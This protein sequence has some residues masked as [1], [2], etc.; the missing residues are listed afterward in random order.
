METHPDVPGTSKHPDFLVH[1]SQPFYLE[2]VSVG[3]APEKRT[4]E[5]R[6]RDVEAI[7]DNT[8]VDGWTLSFEWHRIGP[9]PPKAVRLRNR[10]VTWLDDLDRSHDTDEYAGRPKFS[11]DD[12]G[13]KLD[14]TA[15][16][17]GSDQ[18]PL[19]AI[20]GAGRARGAD[21]KA[22]L[23]R[24]LGAKSNRYGADLPYPLVTAVLSNTESPTRP[25]DVQ[26]TL[27]GMHWLGPSQV[28]DFTELSTDGH[29]RTIHGW[30][31]SHNPY[32]VVGSGISL[33]NIHKAVPWLWRTLD[34]AVTVNLHMPWAAPIDVTV[35][36][37]EA[38]LASANLA[39]LGIRDDW[40][41][42]EPDFH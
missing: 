14:F 15:L 42:G 2:A 6:H 23:N 18:A 1:A 32:V 41:A 20:R 17:V 40:C 5:R 27:Y 21:N 22:G 11:Y 7:L 3:M 39:E 4:S 29:W 31:R 19:V 37:P 16:P 13:W 9:R 34:P 36:E 12:D 38:P 33:Y 8:R 26:P 30:R 35:A 25:Y 28:A 10:L 24:V